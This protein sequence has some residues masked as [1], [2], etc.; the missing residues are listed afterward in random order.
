MAQVHGFKDKLP[1]SV[2]FEEHLGQVHRVVAAVYDCYLPKPGA[3]SWVLKFCIVPNEY[4]CLV[5]PDLVD[6]G[7]AETGPNRGKVTRICCGLGTLRDFLLRLMPQV[8]RFSKLMCQVDDAL[9]EPLARVADI[10][11]LETLLPLFRVKFSPPVSA[12][13]GKFFVPLSGDKGGWKTSFFKIASRSGTAKS[14]LLGDKSAAKGD[15]KKPVMC[16]TPYCGDMVESGQGF[17]CAKGHA[18]CAADFF[19][20]LHSEFARPGI[21]T[22]G[23]LCPAAATPQKCQELVTLKQAVQVVED[24]YGLEGTQIF[25]HAPNDQR[26]AVSDEEIDEGDDDDVAADDHRVQE[27]HD[28]AAAGDAVEEDDEDF[29]GHRRRI[30]RHL[31]RERARAPPPPVAYSKEEFLRL[32]NQRMAPLA[33]GVGDDGFVA[34][35]WMVEKVTL[36]YRGLVADGLYCARLTHQVSPQDCLDA[37]AAVK[38]SPLKALGDHLIHWV[39]E[40]LE[41]AYTEGQVRRCPKCQKAWRKDAGTCTHMTCTRF[42]GAHFCYCC[43][44]RPA[45]NE[46]DQRIVLS[47]RGPH[48]GLLVMNVPTDNWSVAVYRHT[49]EHKR[50]DP[51]DF[52]SPMLS[53]CPLYL[54]TLQY[55]YPNIFDPTREDPVVTFHALLSRANMERWL[56]LCGPVWVAAAL[57]KCDEEV[58]E[59]CRDRLMTTPASELFGFVD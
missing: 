19:A 57:E 3:P 58:R 38:A 10:A 37:L 27:V 45:E 34:A 49:A 39:A 15:I 8:S 52:A 47:G 54:E 13:Q 41:E 29:V 30:A 1:L 25:K 23:L 12:Q 11:Y 55:S 42:C 33:L 36:F 24:R 53:K 51:V 2:A 5:Y 21:F 43:G 59:F 31:A 35:P 6:L 44:L 32:V 46:T 4:L 17:C 48:R 20:W 28:I 56:V 9:W 14:G 50:G 26:A 22:K 7:E 18:L 16:L 40:C